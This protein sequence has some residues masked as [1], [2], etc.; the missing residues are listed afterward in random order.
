MTEQSAIWMVRGSG[1]TRRCLKHGIVVSGCAY[2]LDCK[3]CEYAQKEIKDTPNESIERGKKP[4]IPNLSDFITVKKRVRKEGNG[5]I[6]R[7]SGARKTVKVSETGDT[8]TAR[9][10][11]RTP[12]KK[13]VNK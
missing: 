8:S 4:P 12:N 11:P 1:N 3:D 13:R 2:H 9:R 10:R 6:Y 5:S 7:P